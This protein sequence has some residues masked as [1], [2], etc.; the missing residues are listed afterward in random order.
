MKIGV[1]DLADKT[2]E[3]LCWRPALATD[4]RQLTII[5]QLRGQIGS[6]FTNVCIRGKAIG[7]YNASLWST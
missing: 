7:G 4:R 1:S 2:R 5:M 3:V 6:I